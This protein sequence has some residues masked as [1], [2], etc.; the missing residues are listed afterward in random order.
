MSESQT[1]HRKWRWPSRQ[2]G[3]AHVLRDQQIRPAIA[4]TVAGFQDQETD[5]RK[6]RALMSK[7]GWGLFR[8]SRRNPAK[9]ES[10]REIV[11][12]P[13]GWFVAK[14]GRVLSARHEQI[15]I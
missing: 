12:S 4:V 1:I 7:A 5:T 14:S 11:A 15:H 2:W 10:I 9:S 13:L 6:F 8:S 3:P